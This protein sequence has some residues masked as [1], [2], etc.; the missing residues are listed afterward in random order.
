[1]G[2]AFGWVSSYVWPGLIV[3]GRATVRLYY[4]TPKCTR[5][6]ISDF[7][8][9]RSILHCRLRGISRAIAETMR[10]ARA[11]SEHGTTSKHAV[12]NSKR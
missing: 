12:S 10:V 8:F 6:A 9:L 4:R 2:S 3:C 11:A 1:M 5:F 7:H